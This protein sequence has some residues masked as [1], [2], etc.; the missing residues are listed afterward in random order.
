VA[1][2]PD[3]RAL[4]R[5]VG[6][7]ELDRVS[8]QYPG[9]E[10]RAL[11]QVSLS[12]GPGQTL[13]VVGPSGAGKST[14]VRLLLRFYDPDAGAV[15]LDGH[16]LRE[17]ELSSLRDAV[18]VVFQ[19]TLLFDATVREN[20]AYG[21]PDATEA[22][23]AAAARAAEAAEFIEVLPLGY[24]TPVG[25]K[26]RLLSGGQRQRIAIARA[27]L[28]DAPVLVLDEPTAGLDAETAERLAT[29]LFRLM[30]GRATI[31]ATHDLAAVQDATAIAVLE[32]GRLVELGAH[33][34]LISSDGLYARLWHA[35]ALESGAALTLTPT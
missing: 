29:P 34:Q 32:R 21:R 30:E 3:A 25:Q 11:E 27:F 35:Q 6:M 24:E 13:A 20:I 28:R 14:V 16:D 19:D 12:V 33:D 23:I 26:G 31:V 4:V 1:E 9:A 5:P 2:R 15:R 10:R 17:L 22:E 8:F 7:I 18:A